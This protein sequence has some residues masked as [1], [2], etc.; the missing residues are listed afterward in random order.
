[1]LQNAGKS[2]NQHL[3][4]FSINSTNWMACKK[5][6]QQQQRQWTKKLTTLCQFVIYI[7]GCNVFK[8]ERKKINGIEI[9]YTNKISKLKPNESMNE[10]FNDLFLFSILFYTEPCPLN[11]NCGKYSCY[12]CFSVFFLILGD[13]VGNYENV[14][15]GIKNLKK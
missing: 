5:H 13:T 3:H 11:W 10:M 7:F 9:I 6:Q 12:F 4:F 15:T 1:M 2:F 14:T 8:R